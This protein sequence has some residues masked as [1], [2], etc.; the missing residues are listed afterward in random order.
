[1][2]KPYIIMCEH[3]FI[4]PFNQEKAVQGKEIRLNLQIPV[5]LSSNHTT[6]KARRRLLCKRNTV[7]YHRQAAT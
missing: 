1:M 4:F 6:P 5:S 2:Y 7:T 3:Y